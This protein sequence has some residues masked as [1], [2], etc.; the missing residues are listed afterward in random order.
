MERVTGCVW[1]VWLVEVQV[2]CKGEWVRRE[3]AYANAR[4]ISAQQTNLQSIN[5]LVEFL[6]LGL[7]V[8]IVV[9]LSC[10]TGVVLLRDI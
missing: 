9:P 6:K 2:G 10:D 3:G 4:T 7:K 8:D 5:D 1:I